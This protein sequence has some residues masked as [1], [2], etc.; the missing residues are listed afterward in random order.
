MLPLYCRVKFLCRKK[1]P[2]STEIE[3][4]Y[5]A[6]L[7]YLKVKMAPF[8]NSR[9]IEAKDVKNSWGLCNFVTGVIKVLPMG[10]YHLTYSRFRVRVLSG[11]FLEWWGFL[12]GLCP[13]RWFLG[14]SL[15]H[16]YSHLN[17]ESKGKGSITSFKR[18]Y[19]TENCILRKGSKIVVQ[20]S[21]YDVI[22][23][24]RLTDLVIFI[25]KNRLFLLFI[26]VSL[27]LRLYIDT[28][29]TNCCSRGICRPGLLTGS[30]IYCSGLDTASFRSIKFLYP[31]ADTTSIV[32]SDTICVLICNI[33]LLLWKP[34][35]VWRREFV[36]TDIPYSEFISR[37]ESHNIILWKPELSVS[38]K[39]P[40]N[41]RRK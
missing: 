38:R 26:S 36:L 10:D 5:E 28:R 1:P 39:A 11:C 41:C 31:W 16:R 19:N 33:I 32:T 21:A 7:N 15:I 9:R 18:K 25:R 29:E 20:P 37:T 35:W 12:R 17:R 3:P 23:E 24:L 40:Q 14:G 27:L 8:K 30:W 13:T 22:C 2:N 4:V 34:Y 6:N